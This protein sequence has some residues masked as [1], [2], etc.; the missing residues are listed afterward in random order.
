MKITTNVLDRHRPHQVT[1]CYTPSTTPYTSGASTRYSGLGDTSGLRYG[2]SS[3]VYQPSVALMLPRNTSQFSSKR[4]TE[5][6]P[7]AVDTEAI[8]PARLGS[9]GPAPR[10]SPRSNWYNTEDRTHI[11]F[12]TTY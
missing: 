7:R 9:T 10:P 2:A 12:E 5:V 8:P 11:C 3:S 4:Y 6:H 1:Q